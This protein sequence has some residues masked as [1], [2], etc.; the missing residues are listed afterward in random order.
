ML[1]KIFINDLLK[2]RAIVNHSK[3]TK[4]IIPQIYKKLNYLN[5]WETTL[6]HDAVN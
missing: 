1:L 3:L 4:R 5:K 6:L 2:H